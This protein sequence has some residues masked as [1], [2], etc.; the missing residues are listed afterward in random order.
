V[1]KKLIKNRYLSGFFLNYQLLLLL[2]LFHQFSTEK[3]HYFVQQ[4]VN[5]IQTTGHFEELQIV[6]LAVRFVIGDCV[7][8]E[9]ASTANRY[10]FTVLFDYTI[11]KMVNGQKTRTWAT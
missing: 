5:G 8:A 10:S 7:L 4:K 2:L 1:R 9:A 11:S 6:R 3:C